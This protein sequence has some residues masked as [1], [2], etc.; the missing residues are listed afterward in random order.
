MVLWRNWWT[1]ST[2]KLINTLFYIAAFH[3]SPTN[4][5]LTLPAPHPPPPSAA[6]V[7]ALLTY[8]IQF[9]PPQKKTIV[10]NNSGRDSN[11]ASSCPCHF[12]S[13]WYKQSMK[14]NK[15]MLN[16][17]QC[18]AWPSDYTSARP[19]GNTRVLPEASPPGRTYIG[20][21]TNAPI[22]S[23]FSASLDALWQKPVCAE[24]ER[25]RNAW[26]GSLIDAICDDSG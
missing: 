11:T 10:E 23:L 26:G 19:Q 4:T 7:M 21:Q 14:A 2:K 16:D 1:A 9:N 6:E 17:F 3:F 20:S 8:A 25:Q 15:R 18:C 22:T 24:G 13:H 5:A 12:W